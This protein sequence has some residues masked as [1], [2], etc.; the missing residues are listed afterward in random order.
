MDIMAV[1]EPEATRPRGRRA[2]IVTVVLLALGALACCGVPAFWSVARQHDDDHARQAGE[3]VLAALPLPPDWSRSPI[4][5]TGC[6][7]VNVLCRMSGLPRSWTMD[8]SPP[9]NEQAAQVLAT[10]YSA[11]PAVG[12]SPCDG[13]GAVPPSFRNI[14]GCWKK[15]GYEVNATALGAVPCPNDSGRQFDCVR[16]DVRADDTGIRLDVRL[17]A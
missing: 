12:W 14:M 6:S 8:V 13:S 10:L 9:A 1:G 7:W 4:R 15:D 5:Y 11:L 3:Q 17:R 16:S 2:G